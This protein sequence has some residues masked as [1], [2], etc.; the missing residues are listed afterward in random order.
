MSSDEAMSKPESKAKR[1]IRHSTIYAIGN[2]SRQLAG[3]LMLPVYTHFLTPS[4]YGV[5]GLLT[6]A[7]ALLEPFFGARLGEA[8]LKFYYEED[9]PTRRKT[10]ISTSLLITGIVS[11]VVSVGA[12]LARGPASDALFGTHAYDLAV[13]LFAFMFVTQATEYY[14]LTFIRIQEK[15]FLFITVNLSKLVLQ[16]ALNIWFIVYAHMGVMGVVWSGI[17]TSGLY[18][19]G[20]A[21]YVVIFNG[22]RIDLS[23]A[24]RML[25]FSWPLWLSSIAMLYIY[26]S[27]RYFIRVF[28]SLAEVGYFEL[29]SKFSAILTLVVWQPFSQFWEMERFAYYKHPDNKQ[30][31]RSVFQFASTLLF[32]GALGISIFADPVIRI[33]SAPEF[34]AASPLVPWLTFGALFSFLTLFVN[35]SFLITEQTGRVSRNNYLVA[36][37]VTVLNFTMIPLWG[38]MGAGYAIALTLMIQFVIVHKVA[39]KYY[40]MTLDLAPVFVMLLIGAAGYV[41]AGE[42]LTIRSLWLDIAWRSIVFGIFTLLMLFQVLR[43]P[44]NK[45]YVGRLLGSRAD[46]ILKRI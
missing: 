3:F 6:F 29:A 44:R 18:A 41:V 15:P 35:F 32:I 39:K 33:M 1:L 11:T 19:A 12:F 23:L 16:L 45:E 17:I 43:S 2:I 21:L 24:R 36:G 46:F 31:F 42:I 25:I 34:H 22:V 7:L 14:G 20:L 26:S 30:L 5:V 4:D 38:H 40:D 9:E 13:G 10:V 27:N 28:G 37:I 8:M